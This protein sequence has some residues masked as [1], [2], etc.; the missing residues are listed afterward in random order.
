MT[1]F[2]CYAARKDAL[3]S[4]LAGSSSPAAAAK[5][6][7]QA[8]DM[9]QYQYCE[10]CKSDFLRE[11]CA[12]MMSAAKSSFPLLECV[13]VAKIWHAKETPQE[14]KKKPRVLPAVALIFA[15]LLL[16]G[17]FVFI[18]IS[19]NPKAD[20][21]LVQTACMIGGGCCVLFFIA[22]LLLHRRA[23]AKA[24]AE[25]HV[26]LAA[27]ADDLVRRLTAVILQIDKNLAAADAAEAARRKNA[28]AGLSPQELDLYAA[29]LENCCA[30][31]ADSAAESRAELEH[32]LHGRGVELSDYDPARERLFELLP[33]AGGAQT[34]RPA[35]LRD[36]KLLRKGL[37]TCAEEEAT[38]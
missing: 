37:A 31:D 2:D 3:L 35:L 30:G 21:E 25:T 8:F 13:R 28:D 17:A 7:E 9:V 16:A 33:S 32:F 38:V 4:R 29:L 6:L 14:A 12:E 24:E 19:Q 18:Y 23:K 34:L 20:M 11:R 26:E 1:L 27:A 10:E 36:G 22:G 15:A 5:V